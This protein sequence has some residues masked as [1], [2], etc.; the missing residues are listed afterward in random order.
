MLI[1]SGSANQTRWLKLTPLWVC[2]IKLSRDGYI[3][4]CYSVQVVEC[5]YFTPSPLS[6]SIALLVTQYGLQLVQRWSVSHCDY[7]IW[8][9]RGPHSLHPSNNSPAIPKDHI[10][11]DSPRA[12]TACHTHTHAYIQLSTL[13]KDVRMTL[14]GEGSGGHIGLLSALDEKGAVK[15]TDWIF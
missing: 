8:P 9:P 14:Q 4:N 6:V 3:Y 7:I 5:P 10:K 2:I 12:F 15:D 13:Y 1:V 11:H